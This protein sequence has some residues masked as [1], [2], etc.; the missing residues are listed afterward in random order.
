V[1]ESPQSG[2][3]VDVGEARIDPAASPWSIPPWQTV[4]RARAVLWSSGHPNSLPQWSI[5]SIRLNRQRDWS[6]S[7]PSRSS[8][9][10]RISSFGWPAA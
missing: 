4:L 10:R 1:S 7:T 5:R 6:P 2:E 8:A 9:N 3:W